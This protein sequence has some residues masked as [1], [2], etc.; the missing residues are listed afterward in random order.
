[1][2]RDDDHAAEELMTSEWGR[3]NVSSHGGSVQ[4]LGRRSSRFASRSKQRSMVAPRLGDIDKVVR[5][6][7]HFSGGYGRFVQ[8]FPF[9]RD[10][11][12]ILAFSDSDWAGRAMTQKTTSGGVLVI[13]QC[14]IKH[15][16]AILQAIALPTAEAALCAATRATSDAKGLASLGR[17]F[18][19]NLRIVAFVDTRK[20]RLALVHGKGR[21]R[22]IE[23]VG[24]LIQYMFGRGGCEL[25]QKSAGSTIPP[26]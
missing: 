17:G 22:H 10:D 24:F 13:G 18:G 3:D 16:S 25:R 4:M 19:E 11:G 8:R 6:A 12:S 9:G 26:T 1:M 5:I 15:W 23:T 2:Q 21:A 14:T 7:K 20:R